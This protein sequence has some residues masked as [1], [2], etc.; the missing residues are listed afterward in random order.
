M[1]AANEVAVEDF[2][3]RRIGF[4]DIAEVVEG[5]MRAMG[6]PPADTLDAVLD[7][8]AR[9]RDAARHLAAAIRPAA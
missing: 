2:L 4:L 5:V 7:L 1:S 3:A 6:A 9:A 8:D